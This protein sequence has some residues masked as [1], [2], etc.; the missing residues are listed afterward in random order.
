MYTK[1]NST[2]TRTNG[3]DATTHITNVTY[4]A[5]NVIVSIRATWL[6]R[7]FFQ[8]QQMFFFSFLVFFFFFWFVID[9]ISIAFLILYA[10]V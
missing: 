4:D 10:M 9:E 8:F 7:P 3:V 5:S 6:T 2:A 1:E